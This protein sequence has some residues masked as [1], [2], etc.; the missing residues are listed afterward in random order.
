MLT[1]KNFI[2]KARNWKLTLFEVCAPFIYF[3]VEWSYYMKYPHLLFVLLPPSQINLEH[4]QLYHFT[5]TFGLIG[6]LHLNLC[7]F[8][9]YHIPREHCLQFT[10]VTLKSMGVNPFA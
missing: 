10:K 2:L 4:Y 7:L 6:M 1:R 3:F 8:P 5:V 9:A